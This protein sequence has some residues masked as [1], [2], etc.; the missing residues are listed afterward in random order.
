MKVET[1]L[2]IYIPM[3][4]AVLLATA[5]KWKQPKMPIDEQTKCGIYEQ[6]NITQP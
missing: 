4:T 5:K 3:F 6:W 2:G 1:R